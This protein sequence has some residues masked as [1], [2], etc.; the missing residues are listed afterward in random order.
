MAYRSLIEALHA[1]LRE[2][3]IRN[4]RPAYGFVLLAAR[5]SPIGVGD[6]GVLLGMTKQAASKLVDSME[7]DGYA[8]R[9]TDEG[10]AR[11]RRIELTK[12]GH[13]LL[14]AVEEIYRELEAQWAAVVGTRGVES[15]RADL[16]KILRAQNDGAL[17][18]VRPTW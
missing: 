14:D 4:V 2:R 17:P 15:I 12:S 3:G 9:V 5:R 18:P 6:I 10:D 16:T 7:A 13:R 11:A 1:R 8:R